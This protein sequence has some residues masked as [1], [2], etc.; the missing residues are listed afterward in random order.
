MPELPLHTAKILIVDDHQVN[1]HLLER[2]LRLSGYT[3]LRGTTDPF[4]VLPI[5]DEFQPDLILLD[6]LMPDMDGFAVMEA[7]SKRI[8]PGVYMPIL[9]ITADI[10]AETKLR[11][12]AAGARDFLAKPFDST[13]VML[14][15]KNLLETRM[16]YLQLQRQNL[17][18][19]HKVRER[20]YAL[21]QAQVEILQRLALASEFRDD[22]TGQH[23]QRVGHLAAR[24]AEALGLPREHVDLIRLTAPLH[25]LGK[26]GIPDKILLKPGSLTSDEMSQMR[27]H[28]AIGSRILSGSEHALLRM[29]EEIAYTHHERWN[30]SGYPRGLAGEQIP[31]CGRIVAVADAFDA[32]L[33]ERPYKPAWPLEQVLDEIARQSGTTFDPAVVAALLD[34]YR[35]HALPYEQERLAVGL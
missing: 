28:A 3:R 18:L 15:I 8:E 31:L 25:D 23:T 9:M 22:Q 5:F 10:T 19:D 21:E 29:A 16:L 32:L 14:R 26:I 7:L 17:E 33:H 30:G 11:A 1:V 2:L 27:K 24:L 6:L 20:T 35:Y 13:E 12:L 34:L 4:Q